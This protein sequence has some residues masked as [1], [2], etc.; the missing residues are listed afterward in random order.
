ME[1]ESLFLSVVNTKT[2][3]KRELNPKFVFENLIRN[4]FFNI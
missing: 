4:L 3:R 2:I 1:G